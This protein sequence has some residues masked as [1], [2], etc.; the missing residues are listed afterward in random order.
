MATITEPQLKDFRRDGYLFPIPALTPD[1]AASYRTDIE[2]FENRWRDD[3]LLPEPLEHYLR[4]N[5]HVVSTAAAR[6]AADQAIVDIAAG[7]LGE[8]VLCWMAELI[9]KEPHTDKMLSMHQD[10]TYWGLHA[11]DDLVTIWVA[12]SDATV[13]NGAM[14]FVTGSHRDG[15]ISHRDTYGLDNLLSRGQEIEVEHD[16]IL[17]VPVEL[18]AGEVSVH[19]GLTVHGSGPNT[20]NERRVGVVLRYVNANVASQRGHDYA[21]L[22]RGSN[23][24]RNLICTASPVADCDDASLRLHREITDYQEQSLAADASEDL[25]SYIRGR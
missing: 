8:D 4:A 20:T 5:L 25:F 19:H 2:A 24:S 17:E 11:G 15:Q 13:D 10:L 23:R 18:E 7:F 16:P 14:R 12:L 1:Q 3:P 22:V 21:M 9:V 6:L